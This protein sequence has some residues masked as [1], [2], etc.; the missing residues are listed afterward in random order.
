[1]RRLAGPD[2]EL[3]VQHVDLLV[4]ATV[5][6]RRDLRAA[7]EPRFDKVVEP[8]GV[9]VALNDC[10]DGYHPASRNFS[11]SSPACFTM[12]RLSFMGITLLHSDWARGATVSFIMSSCRMLMNIRY[13]MVL[14]T[15]GYES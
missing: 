9:R 13:S 8:S 7:G 2:G 5:N 15:S 11:S 6:V 14:R 12:R 1:V 10:T 3:P 4:V